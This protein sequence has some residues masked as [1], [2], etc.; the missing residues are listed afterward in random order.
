MRTKPHKSS[1]KKKT[2]SSFLLIFLSFFFAFFC[3][4]SW[5]SLGILYK[6]LPYPSG[7]FVS[8]HVWKISLFSSSFRLKKKAKKL[9]LQRGR[10]C[11]QWFQINHRAFRLNSSLFSFLFFFLFVKFLSPRLFFPLF[12]SLFYLPAFFF[13]VLPGTME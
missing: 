7:W 3:Y 10:L 4:S 13:L 8:Q 1:E 9:L 2:R 6:E 12:Q 5:P 11:H